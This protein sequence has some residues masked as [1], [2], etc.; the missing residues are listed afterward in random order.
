MAPIEFIQTVVEKPAYNEIWYTRADGEKTPI[1]IDTSNDYGVYAYIRRHYYDESN[2]RFVIR[3]SGKVLVLPYGAFANQPVETVVLP[4]GLNQLNGRT[5]VYEEGYTPTLK[6]VN[7][8]GSVVWVGYNVFLGCT[9]LESI[10]IEHNPE[11]RPLEVECMKIGGSLFNINYSP[12]RDAKDYVVNLDRYIEYVN[13]RTPFEPDEVNEALFYRAGGVNFGPN[14]T[15]IQPGIFVGANMTELTIPNHITEVG[16]R[17]FEGCKS[18]R[19]LTISGGVGT[20]RNSAFCDCDALEE[21]II[22]DGSVP[23]RLSCSYTISTVSPFNTSPLKSIYI[24]R[25]IT[26]IWNGEPFS[27]T[28]YSQGIFSVSSNIWNESHPDL[29]TNVTIG[30]NVTAINDYMFSYTPTETITIPSSVTSIGNHAFDYCKRLTSI[31]I[32]NSVTSI[33]AGAFTGCLTLDNLTLPEYLTVIDAN[34]FNDCKNL[35]AI[36]IPGTVTSIGRNAFNNCLALKT[37]T[38]EP[39]PTSAALNLNPVTLDDNRYYNPFTDCPLESANLNRE[40][41]EN[42]FNGLFSQ[43]EKLSSVTLGEQVKNLSASMFYNTAITSIIIP[44]N[45]TSIEKEAFL[46]CRIL[47]R[48]ICEGINPPA[49]GVDVFKSCDKFGSATITVPAGYAETY[50]TAAGWSAYASQIQ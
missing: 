17:A 49:L 15:T 7:I 16:T 40:V 18:L 42:N 43:K 34:A 1:T 31:T 25:N 5:F 38:F 33:G 9:S 27:P 20:I 10:T 21:L 35:S 46:D 50:R 30:Q 41:I 12:F 36:S 13:D 29:K 39:S 45:V 19:K 14:V 6:S 37:I 28:V 3:F 26:Q 48:V 47:N 4:D 2:D 11:G 32:P 23:L 22:E 24:G 8:P 44:S